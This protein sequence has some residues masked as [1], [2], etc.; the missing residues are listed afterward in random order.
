MSAGILATPRFVQICGII[1]SAYSVLEKQDYPVEVLDWKKAIETRLSKSGNK[2]SI[3]ILGFHP[4]GDQIRG[5]L[6][7]YK[8]KADIFFSEKET[9]CWQRYIVTKEL[10]HLLI[11]TPDEYTRR[12][13][14]LMEQLISGIP[15][16][17][18]RKDHAQDDAAFESEKTAMIAAIEMLLPWKHRGPFQKCCDK[19][20]NNQEI[21]EEFKVPK[22][23]VSNMLTPTYSAASQNA[24]KFVVDNLHAR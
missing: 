8:T 6:H 12:P 24:N 18:L 11:D 22:Y 2:F 14:S 13:S 10:A 19:G 20:K 17:L 16:W 4:P 1:Q 3:N 21:A 5:T 15:L 7:R 9:F 23:V